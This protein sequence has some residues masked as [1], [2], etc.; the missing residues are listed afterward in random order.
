MTTLAASLL[1]L[2]APM[3]KTTAF[4]SSPMPLGG[5][6]SSYLVRGGAGGARLAA[7]TKRR[8][9]FHL[10]SETTDTTS[11]NASEEETRATTS[12]KTEI[13]KQGD[14]KNEESD[15][16]PVEEN[17][18]EKPFLQRIEGIVFC[19]YLCNVL[20]L[21]LPVLLVPIAA[22][23][24]AM[25]SAS[26]ATSYMVAS[27]VAK[28]SSV[29]T[30]GGALG[31]SVN[32]FICKEFGSYKC[33]KFYLAGLGIA[34][35]IF[36]LSTQAS[37]MGMSYAACEFFASIQWASLAVMLQNYYA[38]QPVKLGAALTALGLSSTGGQILAKTMG[39]TLSYSFHW[40]LVARFGAAMAIMGSLIISRAPGRHVAAQQQ[41]NKP[42]FQWSSVTESLKAIL[43]SKLFWML[44]LAHAMAFVTRGTDRILGTFFNQVA[45][46]PQSIC[47]GLTL[48]ITLGLV[49]GLVTGS[50]KYA[51]CANLAEKRS[52][53]KKRY[54][55]SVAATLGLVGLSHFGGRIPNR[56]ITAALVA[57]FSGT[58]ASNIA[59]QYFQFP[60]MISQKFGDHKAVVM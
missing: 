44:G 25:S 35:L 21:S 50:R 6:S 46:L 52:F 3:A 43:G 34:S 30:L 36:S 15:I 18:N 24:M 57:L 17:T 58:M 41:N 7:L 48:S 12:S 40:R 51:K 20:A 54:I 19:A 49:Y 45:G 59:F 60:A 26:S 42:P 10:W 2:C 1:V 56:Y 5:A 13:E 53:L 31:K 38:S 11:I 47:G 29:A 14:V 28:I 9:K 16:I 23:E 27:Q 39:M 33:S 22:E 32:G 55:T 37:T 4:A 8:K